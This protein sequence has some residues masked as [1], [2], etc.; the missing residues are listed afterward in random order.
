MVD[1]HPL[2]S[3]IVP[4][5]NVEKYIE[6]CVRSIFEQTY[7]NLEIIFVNDCTLDS[8]MDILK[9]V[10]E[11]YPNRW[12]Q[13]K[14]IGHLQNRGLAAARLT[15]LRSATGDYILNC[16]SDD[17][18]NKNM[19]FSMVELA[20]KEHADITICDF[21]CVYSDC[22]CQISTNPSL[23]PMEC[24]RQV[25]TGE[26]HS[27]LWNKLIRHSLYTDHDI[28]PIEGLNMREDLSVMYR[29]MFFAQK[30][31]YIP[32]GFY[33][34]DLG[35]PNSYTSVKMSLSHQINA[36]H[37]IE[38]MDEFREL[39]VMDHSSNRAF[40]Y[41]KSGI[42]ASI[43]LYGDLAYFK[44]SRTYFQDVVLCD[45]IGRPNMSEVMKVAGVFLY[46][47]FFTPLSVLRFVRKL[48][49]RK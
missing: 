6:R 33:Y 9:N 8:S 13:T 39:H 30:L 40:R 47:R 7:K 48:K 37:L 32:Q 27:S 29:L 45:I 23:E 49:H 24:M 44:Q 16:D 43:A 31:A 36:M 17:Y 35:N 5:Y 2:V 15:G 34:Y 3:V 12:R 21:F 19:L 11:D 26:V 38:Q 41:F 46:L 14:I 18:L 4:I 1:S 22:I 20:E 10:L 42:M 25:L 28:Y